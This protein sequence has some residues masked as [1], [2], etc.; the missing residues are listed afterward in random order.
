MGSVGVAVS[1]EARSSA[2][3]MEAELQHQVHEEDG[4]KTHTC[5]RQCVVLHAD[6]NWE[7]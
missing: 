1:V 2:I 7:D 4:L 5:M 3:S 6:C